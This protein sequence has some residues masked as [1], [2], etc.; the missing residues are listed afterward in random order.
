MKNMLA[1]TLFGAV[2]AFGVAIWAGAVSFD[3]PWQIVPEFGEVEVAFGYIQ[4]R[5]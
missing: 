2:L 5:K 4:G 3:W 1:G